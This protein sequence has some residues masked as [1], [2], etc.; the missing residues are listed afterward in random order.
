MLLDADRRRRR[1]R[2]RYLPPART[3]FDVSRDKDSRVIRPADERVIIRVVSD[4]SRCLISNQKELP[5]TTWFFR[6]RNDH[7]TTIGQPAYARNVL[8]RTSLKGPSRAGLNVNYFERHLGEFCSQTV[9]H[10]SNAFSIGRP[11]WSRA[12][13]IGRKEPG[14]GER[15]SY[16]HRR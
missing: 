1:F 8:P 5:G 9:R 6:S 14:V 2:Q 15:A 3:P 7:P 11:G 10:T 16:E 13:H 12:A 4:L